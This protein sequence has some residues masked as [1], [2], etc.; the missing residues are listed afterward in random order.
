MER[1][2]GLNINEIRALEERNAI[3]NGDRHLVSLNY[4]FL[5]TLEQYQMNKTRSAKGGEDIH[6]QGSSPPDNEN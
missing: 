4:T 5:D 2:S 1:I 6:E 3:E